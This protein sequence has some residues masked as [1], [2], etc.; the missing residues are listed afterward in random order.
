MKYEDTVTWTAKPLD[1]GLLI[2][3]LKMLNIVNITNKLQP[4]G[5]SPMAGLPMSKSTVSR[6]MG[7]E[8]GS[9]ICV[10]NATEKYGK[11]GTLFRRKLRINKCPW[12][13]GQQDLRLRIT[14]DFG[15]T[16]GFSGGGAPPKIYLREWF[17]DS[18]MPF[19]EEFASNIA[20]ASQFMKDL[21]YSDAS[22]TIRVTLNPREAR[23]GSPNA[24]DPFVWDS[25]NGL[26]ESYVHCKLSDATF[27]QGVTYIAMLGPPFERNLY[28]PCPQWVKHRLNFSEG[29]VSVF[30][31]NPLGVVQGVGATVEAIG[32]DTGWHDLE[33][34]H[35]GTVED[36]YQIPK[37]NSYEYPNYPISDPFNPSGPGV[38]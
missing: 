37:P 18:M 32:W 31:L 22:A 9:G 8:G 4:Y 30:Y 23:P 29:I 24:S 38:G 33:G 11:P 13:S 5:L 35:E 34:W 25:E 27:S 10:A 14:I 26:S 36:P 17:R 7:F 6:H 19:S 20:P 15:H 1:E 3:T 16:I 21:G 28:L 12:P 2:R